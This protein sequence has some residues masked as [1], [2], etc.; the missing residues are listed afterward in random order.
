[1]SNSIKA[2]KNRSNLQEIM[3]HHEQQ[4]WKKNPPREGVPKLDSNVCALFRTQTSREMSCKM[5][6]ERED[7]ELLKLSTE[8]KKRGQEVCSSSKSTISICTSILPSKVIKKKLQIDH[9]LEELEELG[10][11][12]CPF[13]DEATHHLH[14]EELDCLL[15]SCELSQTLKQQFQRVL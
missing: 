14:L 10:W 11:E 2:K 9:Y 13:L 1:M 15:V 3:S 5:V 8:I 6:Q 7:H 4:R 12:M